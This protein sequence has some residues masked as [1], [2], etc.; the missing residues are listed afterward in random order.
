MRLALLIYDVI[1]SMFEKLISKFPELKKQWESYEHLWS[2]IEVP[3]KTVLLH[4]GDI[5]KKVFFIEK[6]CIRA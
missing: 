5:A 1:L 3:A 2:R 6:G 4:E